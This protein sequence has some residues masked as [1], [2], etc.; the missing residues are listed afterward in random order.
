MKSSLVTAGC[1]SLLWA[2]SVFGVVMLPVHAVEFSGQVN[3]EHRQFVSHGLQGQQ[4][5]QSSLVLQPEWYWELSEGEASFTFV[6]FYRYDQ[7][8][9][10]RTHGD[11]REAL[12]LTYWDD[13][14]LRVGIGKVFWGVTESAHLVDVIN[15]TDAI[16]S[17]DGED[18]LGQPMLHFSTT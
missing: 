11:I 10:E 13:Y 9:S 7:M 17:V 12:Y 4:K 6:P 18:K 3:V 8:D 14:E 16:E 15:Q 2:A 1:R 5:G